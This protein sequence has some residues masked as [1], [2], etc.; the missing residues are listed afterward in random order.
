MDYFCMLIHR[1][2]L[3][4]NWSQEGLCKG[5]CSV[6]YL[7]KIEQGKAVPSEEILTALLS[8]LDIA[9]SPDPEAVVE[10][11]YEAL[12][13]GDQEGLRT[14]VADTS[15][16]AGIDLLL[17]R[18]FADRS[19]PLEPELE[20]CMQGG[21]RLALQR[22]MQERYDE[23]VALCPNGFF[24]RSVGIHAYVK[25]NDARALEYLQ[26]AYDLAS[27]EGRPALMLDV[28]L[29]MGNCYSNR[30]DLESMERH[31]QVAERL[32]Q[33]LRDKDALAYIRYNRAATQME[34]GEYEAAYAF[35]SSLTEPD[36]MALHKL[37]VCCEKLGRPQEA[38]SA[39]DRA[40]ALTS[41]EVVGELQDSMCAIVRFRLEHPDYISRPEYGAALLDCFAQLRQKLP[42][43]Y[44]VFHLPWVL[45]WYRAN[46][47]YRPAYDLLMDF[48]LRPRLT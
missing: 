43:G 32:A 20:R 6:S 46:R 28:Q 48:P 2:R 12:F 13:S 23:A 3:R 21:R 10:A 41:N 14:I 18:A 19:G 16:H 33:A 31:Y 37:A 8:R 29:Y 47:Q 17:L 1:E 4:R 26:T 24:Y 15:R 40:D 27:Q 44:A 5:I 22:L 39:L 9:A 38:L 35:F 30:I 25:G 36:G 42:I 34:A 45:E 7:S 11:A